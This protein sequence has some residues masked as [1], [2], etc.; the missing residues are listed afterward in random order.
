MHATA[1]GS[2]DNRQIPFP[3]QAEHPRLT[4]DRRVGVFAGRRSLPLDGFAKLAAFGGGG[5]LASGP[6]NGGLDRSKLLSSGSIAKVREARSLT[7]DREAVQ[8]K[9]I[10]TYAAPGSGIPKDDPTLV[11]MT[12]ELE[13]TQQVGS[14]LAESLRRLGPAVQEPSRD[15]ED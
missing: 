1:G 8:S 3:K 14:G 9:A 4:L 13:E 15:V 11:R 5:G 12:R 2:W 7:A 10:D 6:S